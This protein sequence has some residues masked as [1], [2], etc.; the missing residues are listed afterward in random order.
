MFSEWVAIR[1][2]NYA[3]LKKLAQQIAREIE[4]MPYAVLN[5]PKQPLVYERS[6]D[7]IKL[8]WPG[9]VT[10]TKANGDIVFD[11]EFRGEVPTLF[12]VMPAHNFLRSLMVAS[13]TNDNRKEVGLIHCASSLTRRSTSLP[14][15]AG[16]CAIKPRSAG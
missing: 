16:R 15:V 11:M 4:A 6:I 7:G 5:D 1:K 3:M 8:M 2:R 10:H 12:G 14:S 13:V 9:D